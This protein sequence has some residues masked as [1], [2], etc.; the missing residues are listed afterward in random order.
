MTVDYKMSDIIEEKIA[1]NG[2]IV[3]P[4][5]WRELLELDDNQTVQL[6]L[7]EDKIIISKKE[8]P[9]TRAIGLFDDIPDFTDEEYR[10]AKKSLFKSIKE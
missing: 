10:E 7:V 5:K 4:K 2:R 1:S 6:E 9:L 3:I 8:H